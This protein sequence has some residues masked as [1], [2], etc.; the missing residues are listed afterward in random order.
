MINPKDVV[1]KA[2][3]QEGKS[4]MKFCPKCELKNVYKREVIGRASCP[5]HNVL[6]LE[7]DEYE[8]QMENV[9]YCERGR[10]DDLLQQVKNGTLKLKRKGK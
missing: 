7:K 8:F 9:P 6:L 3:M 5:E 10:T 1:T 4:V 2:V